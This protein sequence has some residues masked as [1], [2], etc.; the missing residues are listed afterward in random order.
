M[1][2]TQIYR[3]LL[4]DVHSSEGAALDIK[5]YKEG[6]KTSLLQFDPQVE[7]LPDKTLTQGN[8]V[9]AHKLITALQYNPN[10]PDAGDAIKA[11]ADR[12]KYFER[13]T[14]EEVRGLKGI[15]KEIAKG[16][17]TRAG[18]LRDQYDGIYYLHSSGD[19]GKEMASM[20][21]QELGLPV[22]A[23]ER[24][25]KYKAPTWRDLLLPEEELHALVDRETKGDRARYDKL[26]RE[27]D[28]VA[29][30]YWQ[31]AIERGE[32]DADGTEFRSTK[33]SRP[34]FRRY[35]KS[36]YIVKQLL[37]KATKP[38]KILIVDDNVHSQ[39]DFDHIIKAMAKHNAQNPRAAILV[40]F[41]AV[42]RLGFAKGTK[43]R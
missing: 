20:L 1:K 31:G 26:R 15:A 34:G 17:D 19:L 41:F 12:M 35:F 43:V 33:L 4:E 24:I 9:V 32:V 8:K 16:S 2:L 25:P 27:I 11:A 7:W 14:P 42:M 5:P 21:A 29:Q 40:D 10:R 36:K 23:Y 39:T 28:K 22:D 30:Q 18:K 37:D 13:L 3:Q 6:S 38:L